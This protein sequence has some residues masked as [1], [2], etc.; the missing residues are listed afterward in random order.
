MQLWERARHQV[1]VPEGK[2]AVLAIGC[3]LSLWDPLLLRWLLWMRRSAPDVA[4]RAHVGVPEL[5]VEQVAEGIVDIGVVYAPAT[6]PASGWS[7]WPRKGSSW[8]GRLVPRAVTTSRWNGGRTSRCNM[9]RPPPARATR[10][11]WWTSGRSASTTSSRPAG[12]DIS[13]MARSGR[14]WPMA[15][16]SASPRRRNTPTRPMRCSAR[17]AAR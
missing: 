1:A 6:A 17:V 11:W 9:P 13:V 5:L 15:G 8:Y 16:C 3:E 14:T 2:R 10:R 7:C 4:L 12:R